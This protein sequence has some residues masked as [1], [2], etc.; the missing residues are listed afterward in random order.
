MEMIH[1][2]WVRVGKKNTRMMDLLEG[3]IFGTEK[4]SYI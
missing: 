4:T 1:F 3:I 2:L